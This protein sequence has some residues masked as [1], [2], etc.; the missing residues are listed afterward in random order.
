MPGLPADEQVYQPEFNWTYELGA[1]YRSAGVLRSLDATL[2]YIDWSDAQINGL[3]SRLGLSNLIV[4]N[5]AG[6]TTRGLE[7]SAEFVPLEGLRA[8]FAYSYAE[9]Q[10]RAG[11]DDYGSSSFCGL[12]ASVQ[13]S[14]FCTVGPPRQP[15]PNSPALVPWLDGNFPGR[16]PQVTWH[17]ALTAEPRWAAAGWQPWA[18]LDLNHQDDVYERQI[19]G[20]R[21][22]E[23]TLLDARVGIGRGRWSLET[24]GLNLTD[25][26]YIRASFSR[27]PIFY[28]TQPR[29]LDLIYG[30]GRRYGVT[31]RVSL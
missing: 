24:W 16:A 10:F 27:L 29:P 26:Q 31:L 17:G 23:R 11:S 9:P 1:R 15:T 5:T 3:P 28:P 8:E 4:V 20:A 22:G 25:E 13:V 21:F 14:S 7:L 6:L 30:E 19:N 18:R 12:S 2:Y